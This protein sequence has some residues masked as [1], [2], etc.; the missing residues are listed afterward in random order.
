M[1]MVLSD[2]LALVCTGTLSVLVRY[3]L[4]GQFRLTLYWELWPFLLVFLAAY[5][6]TGMYPGIL[7]SPPQELK[8]LSQA[9]SFSFVFL[10]LTAF[11]L[12]GS[13]LYSR[14][15]FL[16]AWVTLLVCIPL[17]R[18]ITRRLCA[19]RS[20]WGYPAVVFGSGPTARS[21]LNT[22]ILRPRLGVRPV[23]VMLDAGDESLD[24]MYGVPVIG[25]GKKDWSAHKA[26]HSCQIAII[27]MS[28][29]DFQPSYQPL[30]ECFR[31]FRRVIYVPEKMGLS[32]LWATSIDLG[33]I[34]GLDIV[35]KL[36]DPKRQAVKR[37]LDVCL[38][39]LLAPVLAPVMAALVLA[40]RFEGRGP[41]FYKQKR[42]GRHGRKFYIWKFRSMVADADTVLRSYLQEHSHLQKEWERT[43]KLRDDP[44]ITT[45]GRFMRKT[46]LD[47]LP[48][49]WNVL[50]GDLSLVGP[51]PIVAEEVEKYRDAFA[52]YTKVRPG[53]TGLWQISGRSHTSY[54][55][56][57]DLD[58]YYVRNWSIWFDIY[59]LAMTPRA[60]CIGHGAC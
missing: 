25:Y 54:D 14:G 59:I 2:A 28:D 20:W 27:A 22:L 58:S 43:H 46:S 42:I 9:T 53:I 45:L 38:V 34:F 8:K 41:V 48:Q 36:V 10:A 5:A 37:V 7:N 4:E 23:A 52:L 19:K 11:L 15:I 31:R 50:K 3:A 57:V 32:P 39:T 40:L 55:E 49:L 44:R 1:V 24:Q 12:K 6:L 13:H 29:T 51:R 21:V 60:V 26:K 16:M 17:F 47:E 35:Q 56:R 30:D 18:T 33:G